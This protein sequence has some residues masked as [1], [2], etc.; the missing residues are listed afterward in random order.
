MYVLQGKEEKWVSCAPRAAS[1]VNAR[2]YWYP[3]LVPYVYIRYHVQ[4]YI[5]SIGIPY[6]NEF[7]AGD[8]L[9]QDHRIFM[10]L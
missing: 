5:F 10:A 1:C 9:P 6:Q 8:Q 4:L 3:V 2:Q 7:S